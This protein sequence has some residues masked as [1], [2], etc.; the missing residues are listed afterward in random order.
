MTLID[1]AKYYRIIYLPTG[2]TFPQFGVDDCPT[3]VNPIRHPDHVNYNDLVERHL[4]ASSVIFSFLWDLV[5]VD[6]D[7][8]NM[9]EIVQT[10]VS[11]GRGNLFQGMK[12]WISFN[13]PQRN[14]FRDEV[15]V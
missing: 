3:R 1:A 7:P 11:G 10:G 14:R 5:F 15:E 9:A 13:V 6:F 4:T 8:S 12:F 2:F